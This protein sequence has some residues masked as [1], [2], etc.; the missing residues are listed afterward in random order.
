ML[1]PMLRPTAV[2]SSG[3]PVRAMTLLLCRAYSINSATAASCGKTTPKSY[4]NAGKGSHLE[5]GRHLGYSVSYWIFA[6]LDAC[7]RI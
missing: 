7:I 3:C 4:F 5:N 1:N 2:T 6:Y